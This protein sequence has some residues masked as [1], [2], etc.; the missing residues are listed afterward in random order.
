MHVEVIIIALTCC[1]ADAVGDPNLWTRLSGADTAVFCA[2]PTGLQQIFQQLPQNVASCGSE[3]LF[4]SFAADSHHLFACSA[5]VTGMCDSANLTRESSSTMMLMNYNSVTI[6]NHDYTP[7]YHV[8]IV[9]EYRTLLYHVSQASRPCRQNVVLTVHIDNSPVT[10]TL[11]ANQEFIGGL[12]NTSYAYISARQT[13]ASG[14]TSSVVIQLNSHNQRTERRSECKDFSDLNAQTIATIDGSTVL[15]ASFN[16]S[17]NKMSSILC[18]YPVSD[19][20]RHFEYSNSSLPES[21]KNDTTNNQTGGNRS[22]PL[23]VFNGWFETENI[24]TSLLA[25]PSEQSGQLVLYT[26]SAS[27]DVIRFECSYQSCY[28]NDT[29]NAASNVVIQLGLY[30]NTSLLVMTAGTIITVSVKCGDASN[31][32]QCISGHFSAFCGFC[33]GPYSCTLRSKCVERDLPVEKECIKVLNVSGPPMIPTSQPKVLIVNITGIPAELHDSIWLN[34]VFNFTTVNTVYTTLLTGFECMTPNFSLPYGTETE[35]IFVKIQMNGSIIVRTL[36]SSSNSLTFDNG[37]SNFSG[38]DCLACRSDGYFQPATTPTTI[39][40]TTTFSQLKSTPSMIV[41]VSTSVPL[42]VSTTVATSVHV[43]VTTMIFPTTNVSS[44][45]TLGRRRRSIN[46]ASIAAALNGTVV[47]PMANAATTSKRVATSKYVTTAAPTIV[48]MMAGKV[49]C[50]RCSRN[51]KQCQSVEKCTLCETGYHWSESSKACMMPIPTS[52]TV[53]S[54]FITTDATNVTNATSKPTDDSGSSETTVFIIA[55]SGGGGAVLIIVVIAFVCYCKRRQRSGMYAGD[56]GG[57]MVMPNMGTMRSTSFAMESNLPGGVTSKEPD[58]DVAITSFNGHASSNDQEL[59]L[60]PAKPQLSEQELYI[61][62]QDQQS[63]PL[64]QAGPNELYL[65]IK[66]ENQLPSDDLYLSMKSMHPSPKTAHSDDLYLAVNEP[67]ASKLNVTQ[68]PSSQLSSD[69]Y[70]TFTEKRKSAELEMENLYMVAHEGDVSVEQKKIKSYSLIPKSSGTAAALQEGMRPKAHS[71]HPA[72]LS[73]LKKELDIVAGKR[74]VELVEDD[75]YEN[76]PAQQSTSQ[77][78]PEGQLGFGVSEPERPLSGYEHGDPEIYQNVESPWP[79][80]P[81]PEMDD[82][83]D[84]QEV[85][86]AIRRA[87]SKGDMYGD[88][89][90]E[91]VYANT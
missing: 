70:V 68:Q 61:V 62:P 71:V 30:Q 88:L 13:N 31:C 90:E 80:P 54:Q 12:V 46:T 91:Q 64:D 34:C 67:Q 16:K 50:D 76:T 24:M 28:S 47:S 32:L 77:L 35:T 6:I 56:K 51:C 18:K 2:T 26:G 38:T 7:L 14:M 57:D 86:D 69:P 59:Y 42:P 79:P 15:L 72:G 85:V 78:R 10:L 44:N 23:I 89:V 65:S 55:G 37:C 21:L 27:G 45:M 53:R 33:Y 36:G 3:R 29:Y 25:T 20:E 49:T 41:V 5:N 63:V 66:N 43:N 11:D 52:S 1:L 60:Q 4:I 9:R 87:N 81:E 74:K 75:M 19:L 17:K 84:N 22:E 40:P 48:N 8:S 82:I 58:T 73:D 39:L 83:Y